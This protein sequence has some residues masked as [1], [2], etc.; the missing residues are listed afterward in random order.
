MKWLIELNI[1]ADYFILLPSI[2]IS[3]NLLLYPYSYLAE[4]RMITL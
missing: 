2:E 4:Q 1:N 3:L